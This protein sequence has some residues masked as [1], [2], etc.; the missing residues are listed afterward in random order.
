MLFD[1]HELFIAVDAALHLVVAGLIFHV[2]G[3]GHIGAVQPDLPRVDVLVPEVALL[4][5]G[6]GQQLAAD[7]VDGL[8]VFFVPEDVVEGEQVLALIHV[9]EVVFLRV[10]GLDGAVLLHEEVDEVLGKLQILLVAG[11]LVEAQ[12]GGDHAAVDVVPLVGLAAAHLL[13]VPHGGLSAGIGDEVVYI[14]AQHGQDL[15]VCHDVSPPQNGRRWRSADARPRS[16]R[17]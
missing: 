7:G 14:I 13:D 12:A 16:P 15:F 1:V 5:A 4:G 3:L 9:V 8:A 17:S 2:E 11:G 10:V 6:L